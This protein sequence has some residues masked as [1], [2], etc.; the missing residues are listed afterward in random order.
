MAVRPRFDPSREFVAA[1]GF[2]FAG[3]GYAAGD[4]FAKAA[5]SPHK[6]AAMYDSRKINFAPDAA[7]EPPAE[8]P[9][10]DPA[11]PVTVEATGGGWHAIT[12]AWLDEPVKVQGKEAADAEAQRI[13][14]AGEPPY[15]HLVALNPGENGWH[16]VKADWLDEAEKV[17]GEQAARDRAAALRAEGPPEGWEAPEA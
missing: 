3:V 13:R 6:L 4:A 8:P 1:R 9:Q 10:T 15:H 5:S 14:D 7:P 11:D 16:E 2:T 17:Q 12:A